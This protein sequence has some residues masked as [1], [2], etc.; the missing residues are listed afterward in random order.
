VIASSQFRRIVE[1]AGLAQAFSIFDSSEPARAFLEN[2]S[3][4]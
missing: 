3:S 1:Y 4:R 2:G